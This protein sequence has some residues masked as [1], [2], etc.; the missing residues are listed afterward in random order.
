MSLE[1][2]DL[3]NRLLD[4]LG[5]ARARRQ[6]RPRGEVTLEGEITEAFKETQ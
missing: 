5:E 2:V 3:E 4:R 6:Q 1:Q